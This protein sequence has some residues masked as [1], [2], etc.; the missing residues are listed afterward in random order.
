MKTILQQANAF[1]LRKSLIKSRW[2]SVLC[3][4]TA[5]W[6]GALV[7]VNAQFNS[8]MYGFESGATGTPWKNTGNPVNTGGAIAS[9]SDARTGLYAAKA[10]W[11]RTQTNSQTFAVAAA[12][13][14]YIPVNSTIH[15]I[16]WIKSSPAMPE[17]AGVYGLMIATSN[18]SGTFA[19]TNI[20]ASA[21][22][23]NSYTTDYE[24]YSISW[25]R[26]NT[27]VTATA[28]GRFNPKIAGGTFPGTAGGHYWQFFYDDVIMYAS[29]ND[30][31][32]DLTAPSAPTGSSVQDAG[33]SVAFT[34]GIDSNTGVQSSLFMEENRF[35]RYLYP[36][37]SGCL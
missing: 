1:I 30:N 25:K 26:T 13:S 9:G 7:Q 24:R 15:I 21:A 2:L 35:R 33:S 23:N 31:P 16:A 29:T 36:E 22:S 37:R 28:A 17:R 27:G 10:E 3:L 4:I 11:A 19:T 12:W 34:C 32:T 18:K 5:F 20:A 8:G 6:L 14:E